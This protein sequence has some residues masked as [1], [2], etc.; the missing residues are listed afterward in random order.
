M[1][2]NDETKSFDEFRDSPEGKQPAS[3]EFEASQAENKDDE[4]GGSKTPT[5]GTSTGEE[6]GNQQTPTPSADD[7]AVTT[8]PEEGKE[9]EG[10]EDGSSAPSKE[11]KEGQLRAL[12][13]EESKVDKQISDAKQRISEKRAE[14]RGHLDSA[15]DEGLFQRQ[16]TTGQPAEQPAQTEEQ[17]NDPNQPMTR[18]EYNQEESN[19]VLNNFLASE[20]GKVY[21]EE[22]DPHNEYWDRLRS[23]MSLYKEPTTPAG[24]DTVIKKSHQDVQRQSRPSDNPPPADE[25]AKK[26]AIESAGQGASGGSPASS[27]DASTGS[28]DQERFDL[29]YNDAIKGG[30]SKEESESIAKRASSK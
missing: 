23:A 21:R 12:T 25:A 15:K 27:S 28:F 11:D 6:A 30:F 8:V 29:F 2:T 3:E 13:A 9:V 24:W 18:A 19:K 4:Q 17:Q 20:D 10:Q 26:A 16:D 1:P 14:R 22:N 7:T 5:D